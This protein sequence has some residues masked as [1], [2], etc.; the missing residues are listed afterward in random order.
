MNTMAL[1]LA[2]DGR[3]LVAQA[4]AAACRHQHQRITANDHMFDDGLLRATEGF[5]AKDILQNGV[6]GGHGRLPQSGADKPPIVRCTHG[7]WL[8]LAQ[9]PDVLLCFFPARNNV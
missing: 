3:Y 1:L 5:V 4:F 2:H 7:G 9:A 8:T 6:G